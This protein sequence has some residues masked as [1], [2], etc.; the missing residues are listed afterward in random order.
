MDDEGTLNPRNDEGPQHEG[1]HQDGAHRK[2]KMSKGM[3]L[4]ALGL[5]AGL[6]AGGTAASALSASAA[7]TSSSTSSSPS[8]ATTPPDAPDGSGARPGP[9]GSAPVRSD[10]TALTGD[11]LAKAK[12]AALAAV[13]GGS[14][15]RAE[16]DAG[17]GEYEVHMT[18]A[19]GT[20]VTVKLDKN[21]AL[22]KVET[23]MGQGD[24]HPAGQNPQGP[25]SSSSN[26]S[27]SGA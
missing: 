6:V 4:G 16:T 3:R 19:D 13:P 17:D 8:A 21:F 1:P 15:V 2:A 22:I 27:S 14:V 25:S 18:K 26:S 11:N 7:D 9:G 20:V 12:A 5:V 10:E 24:P 23:G